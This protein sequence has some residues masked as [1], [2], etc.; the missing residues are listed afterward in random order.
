VGA[1]GIFGYRKLDDGYF[2]A[3][4]LLSH[5]HEWITV[6]SFSQDGRVRK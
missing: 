5:T 6:I 4:V 1:F 2:C 3:I